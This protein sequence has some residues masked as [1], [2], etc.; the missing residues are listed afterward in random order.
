MKLQK[1]LNSGIN[2][3]ML[4]RI[5]TSQRECGPSSTGTLGPSPPRPAPAAFMDRVVCLDLALY[6]NLLSVVQ[7]GVR[8]AGTAT[9]SGTGA[10]W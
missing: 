9:G 6:L 10:A 8:T 7:E 3:F 1:S 5:L 4:V 2:D